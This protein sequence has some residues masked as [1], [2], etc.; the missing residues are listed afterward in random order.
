MRCD[1]PGG[2]ACSQEFD[3][4]G[5]GDID[6]DELMKVMKNVGVKVTTYELQKMIKDADLDG[7]GT[8]NFEEFLAVRAA[9]ACAHAARW[10]T[11]AARRLR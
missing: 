8:I 11:R 2:V 9:C 7:S 4:D 3:E 1:T 10:S 6:S 5:S